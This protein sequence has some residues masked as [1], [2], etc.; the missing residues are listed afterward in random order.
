MKFHDR[1][2]PY[3]LYVKAESAGLSGNSMQEDL[4][5]QLRVRKK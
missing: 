1:A 2:Q 5:A 4:L 3:G